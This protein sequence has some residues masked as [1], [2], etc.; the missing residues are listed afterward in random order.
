VIFLFQ[1]YWTLAFFELSRVGAI[2]KIAQ[3]T[4]ENYKIRQSPENYFLAV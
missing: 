3:P 2:L 4:R 1:N